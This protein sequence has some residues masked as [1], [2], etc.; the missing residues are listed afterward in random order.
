M[1]LKKTN[2]VT[3]VASALIIGF[4]SGFLFQTG[5]SQNGLVSGDI[6]KASRYNNVKE[7]PEIAVI[8]EKLQND[9]AFFN[10]TKQSIKVLKERVN[11]LST[12]TDETSRLCTDIPELASNVAAMN[13]LSARACNTEAAFDAVSE[14]LNLIRDGK[15]APLYEQSANNAFVGFKKIE[16]MMDA[17]KTFVESA[18]AYLSGKDADGSSDLES[19]IARWSVFSA[20]NAILMQDKSEMEYWCGKIETDGIAAQALN[21]NIGMIS[22]GMQKLNDIVGFSDL[23]IQNDQYGQ[24]EQFEQFEE[25]LVKPE[26][27]RRTE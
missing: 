4:G 25:T 3:Y 21:A 5:R 27:I 22:S 1:Y 12:L 7:D 8:V 2:F 9:T 15:K 6:S 23:I 14:C 19:V 18:T 17:G 20:E 16:N 13:S 24:Y 26:P 11:A 10:Q